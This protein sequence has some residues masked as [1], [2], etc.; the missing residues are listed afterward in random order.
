M[1]YQHRHAA[2]R[3][4]MTAARWQRELPARHRAFKRAAEPIVFGTPTEAER[5]EFV[6]MR[7]E[8]SAFLDAAPVDHDQQ[9][10]TS[11]Q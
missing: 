2:F 4:P 6:R 5:V 1:S 10:D 8:W 7:D 11:H 9:Q 3:R